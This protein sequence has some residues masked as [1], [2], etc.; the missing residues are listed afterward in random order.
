MRCVRGKDRTS[1]LTTE[2]RRTPRTAKYVEAHGATT[3]A[4]VD[5]PEQYAVPRV[6]RVSVVNSDASG[7]AVGAMGVFV[8]AVALKAWLRERRRAPA[9]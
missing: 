2:T 3:A 6:L 8:F 9:G 1:S 7:L 5:V 4:V